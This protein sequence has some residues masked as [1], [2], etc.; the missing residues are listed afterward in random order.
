MTTQE[1]ANVE[2][3]GGVV[4]A[5]M[6]SDARA[7]SDFYQKAFD[8]KEMA[9]VPPQGDGP[10]MHIHLYINGGSVM[11]SDP[12]PD[13][14]YPHVPPAAYVLHLQVKDAHPGWDRAVAAGAEIRLPLARQF[15]GDTYGQ[16]RDPFGVMWSIGASEG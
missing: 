3:K 10:I 9:R 2:V 4:P 8:A 11:L 6:V 12:F 5:L 16:L 14:G 13:H 15:W 1:S 7:A